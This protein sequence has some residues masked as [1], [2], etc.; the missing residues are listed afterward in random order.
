MRAKTLIQDLWKHNL[1]WDDPIEH[2]HLREKWSMRVAELSS[3]TRL[4]FPLM[5][6]AVLTLLLLFGSLLWRF[7]EG[8]WFR[9][10]PSDHSRE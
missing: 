1:N 9:G 6:L 2:L 7:G 5:C 4:Q 3:I 10:L 8:I